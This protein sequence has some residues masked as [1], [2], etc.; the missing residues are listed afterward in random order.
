MNRIRKY[1]DKFQVLIT[2]HH[3]FDSGFELMLGAWNDDHLRN[4]QVKTYNTMGEAVN[5]ATNY[6][7]IN[8]DKLVEFHKDIYVK[9]NKIIKDEIEN[10]QFIVNYEPRIMKPNDVKNIMFDRVSLFGERFKLNYNM[11]DIIGYHI[12]NP[13][14][15]N[16]REIMSALKNVDSLKIKRFEHDHGVIR[17]IGETDIG[18]TYEIVLWTSLLFNWSKWCTLHSSI[19]DKHKKLAFND[20]LK[21]QTKIDEIINIR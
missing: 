18:T 21:A 12:I 4:Y 6:P 19:S 9:L 10:K 5:E 8:W 11:N 7:D 17:L 13:W 14:S 20:V 16:L 15:K 2:P 1:N 3:R